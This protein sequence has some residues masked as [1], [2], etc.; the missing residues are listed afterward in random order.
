[1]CGDQPLATAHVILGRYVP[2][3]QP[4]AGTDHDGWAV[5]GVVEGPALIEREGPYV[6]ELVDAGAGEVAGQDLDHVVVVEIVQRAECHKVLSAGRSCWSWAAADQ[7][8]A[9]VRGA[10]GAGGRVA[11]LQRG[12]LRVPSAGGR[13]VR[14]RWTSSGV[15]TGGAGGVTGVS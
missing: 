5:S 4:H 8:R 3:E 11:V 9:A 1:V 15:G 10:A 14:A 12:T 6:D 7:R 13:R 2:Y